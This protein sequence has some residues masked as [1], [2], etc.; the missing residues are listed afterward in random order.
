MHVFS[1]VYKDAMDQ[2]ERGKVWLEHTTKMLN[3]KPWKNVGLVAFPN[4]DNREALREAGLDITEEK[5][6]VCVVYV[7]KLIFVSLLL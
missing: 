6:K 2:L 5:L 7:R 1:K 4:I 3:I